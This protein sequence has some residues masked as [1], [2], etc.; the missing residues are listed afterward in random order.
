MAIC[1][2]P[3]RDG[4][5]DE[6][7]RLSVGVT[8]P[9]IQAMELRP[10]SFIFPR[11]SS[12][13]LDK[14][15]VESRGAAII[16]V[17]SNVA[18]QLTVRSEDLDMGKVGNRIKPLSDFLWKKSGDAHYTAISHE[19]RLVDSS[20][21][22]ADHREVEVDY[23]MVVGWTRDKPGTYGLTLRFTMSTLE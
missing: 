8:V 2:F 10:P 16:T 4:M 11:I 17:S 3:F 18:W 20:A 5:A 7:S 19:G 1:L 6:R 22:Y 23:R 21:R 9:V 14:G 13:N 15:F 12:S